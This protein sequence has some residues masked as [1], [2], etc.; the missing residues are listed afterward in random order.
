MYS[1]PMSATWKAPHDK[2]PA[3]QAFGWIA[4]VVL[5]VL[6]IYAP[7]T[8]SMVE[9]WLRS[10]TFAHG[11]IVIPVF[12]YLVWQR[13]FE[14]AALP[15]RP[16]LPGLLL[17]F[18]TGFLWLLAE[19]AGAR[20]PSQFA[21]ITLI[22]ETVLTLFGW[23]WLRALIFPC[24][25]LFFAV[26]FGEVFVPT[27]I[28]WTANVTVVA[29]RLVGVPVY[30]EAAHFVL[31]TGRWSVVDACSGIRYLIA[32]AMA[33]CLFAMLMYRTWWRQLLF[34]VASLL[35]PIVA[36]W[37]R[38]FGIVMLGHVSDNKIATGVDHLIYG[39]LFFG[40]VL[41]VLF[42]IG[43]RWREDVPLASRGPA[44]AAVSTLNKPALAVVMTA[45]GAL[46]PWAMVR[47]V[48]EAPLGGALPSTVAVASAAG[49]QP[50]AA[51]AGWSAVM[52]RPALRPPAYAFAKGDQLIGMQLGIYRDQTTSAQ[53]ITSSNRIAPEG[54][55]AAWRVLRQRYSRIGSIQYRETLLTGEQQLLVRDWYWLGDTTTRSDT[56]AKIYLAF[57]RLLRLDDTSAWVLVY[58]PVREDFDAGKALDDF[59]VDMQPQIEAG[60][61]ALVR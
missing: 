56:V 26:P 43:S 8:W 55:G 38:A 60:L 42:A 28:D 9:I 5:F 46:V 21:M 3:V 30:Q 49:W 45:V 12:L 11:F 7:T 15:V 32:S 48:L 13:R 24:A 52:Q 40:I 16:F 25:F 1:R 58:A 34:V 50:A 54:A 18:G 19:L 4:L 10:D 51:F 61:R 36:N 27:L 33:G 14:L 17:M 35:V 22:P 57:D 6:V 29:L 44:P 31:P 53:L 59:I 47:P 23:R 41:F 37:L 20:S 39:W 2:A